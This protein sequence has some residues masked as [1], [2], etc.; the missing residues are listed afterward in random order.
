MRNVGEHIDAYVTGGGRVKTVHRRELQV[1]RWDGTVYEWLG[2]K[3]DIDE[4]LRAPLGCCS[5]R[6]PV[7]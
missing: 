6:S 1:S 4:A 5:P 7:Q 2:E 3:L